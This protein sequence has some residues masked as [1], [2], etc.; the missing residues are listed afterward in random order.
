MYTH[1]LDRHFFP[2]RNRAAYH[3]HKHSSA[4]VDPSFTEFK[5]FASFFLGP[6]SH[7]KASFSVE[8]ADDRSADQSVCV[9]VC[10]C[11]SHC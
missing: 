2:A 9:C 5:R 10:M 8:F 7:E 3:T 6:R 4:Y 1:T 11:V